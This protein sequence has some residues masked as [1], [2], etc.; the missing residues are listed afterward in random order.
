MIQKNKLRMKK[1]TLLKII[2][3]IFFLTTTIFTG[4]ILINFIFLNH[5]QDM[6]LEKISNKVTPKDNIH[7][8]NQTASEQKIVYLTFDD[9]PSAST[10]Q[11]LNILDQYNAKA[12]FFVTGTNSNYN[13][14]I[15]EAYD[16]GH[17]IGLHTY[18][19]N[20]NDIYSS[21]ES[22]FKDLQ[23]ISDMVKEIT[24]ERSDIIRFPGGSSN[25]ISSNVPGL[26]S[27]LTQAIQD[28]GYQYFDWNVDST[29]ASGNEVPVSQ[30][31]E[32]SIDYDYQYI[33]ILFHD[34]ATKD[35]TLEALPFII[36]Y[37]QEKGYIFLGLTKKSPVIHHIINN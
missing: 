28:I 32:N 9:G 26:M 25:T 22:Y 31:I 11:I 30:I 19:H 15:K 34:T 36:E 37:Y 1:N 27:Q 29:D 35:T 24:G 12:T 7:Q 5:T 6:P 3:C 2:F 18:T 4:S 20:Y 10:K 8:E 33:N 13:H 23:A 16:K 21:V 17:S 14:Y